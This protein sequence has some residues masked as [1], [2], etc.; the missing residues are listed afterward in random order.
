MARRP[1]GEAVGGRYIKTS[2]T[3]S[4]LQQRKGAGV[5]LRAARQPL[6]ACVCT[7]RVSEPLQKAARMRRNKGSCPW[8]RVVAAHDAI[9]G[10]ARCR[11][12]ASLRSVDEWRRWLVPQKPQTAAQRRWLQCE[13]GHDDAM[14]GKRVVG[15]CMMRFVFFAHQ[16][17]VYSCRN[18]TPDAMRTTT[19][20]VRPLTRAALSRSLFLPRHL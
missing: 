20:S 2:S 11:H 4:T 18:S 7:L 14:R 15:V 5:R 17:T 6:A 3:H 19:C 13:S 8:R 10:T 1:C 12:P 16:S 9:A